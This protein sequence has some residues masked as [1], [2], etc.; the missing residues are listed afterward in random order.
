M[1]DLLYSIDSLTGKAV[2]YS[3]DACVSG[4]PGVVYAVL[5]ESISLLTCATGTIR[6]VVFN[7]DSSL[8]EEC[9]RLVVNGES[10]RISGSDE[11][12][13]FFGAQALRRLNE[14]SLLKEGVLEDSPILGFRGFKC[15][16]PAPN[17]QSMAEFR[18][19]VDILARY[20]YN[21]IILEIGGAMEFT[22]H[23]E[24]NEGWL[25][26]CRFMNAYSGKPRKIQNGM[27]WEKDSI[28]TTN[29]GGQVV[30]QRMLR[31]L[32]AYC[33]E[34]H[35][36][37]IPEMPS[38]SHCDYLLV[39]HPELAERQ[40]DPFP[41]TACPNHPGYY[42]LL[43]DLFDEII[44]VFHPKRMHI[45]H[46]EWYSIALCPRCKGKN[47]ADLFAEDICRC[48]EYLAGRGI[49][50]MVWSDKLCASTW[51]NGKGCGGSEV[52]AADSV[53]SQRPAT[54]QAIDKLPNDISIMH[55]FYVNRSLVDA[56]DKRGFPVVLGNMY[57]IN[58][59]DWK[60]TIAKNCV[61]GA[62]CSNWGTTDI[63]TLQRNGMLFNIVS[64]AAA[65]WNPNIGSDNAREVALWAIRELYRLSNTLK[66]CTMSFLE[67][68]HTCD[69]KRNATGYCDGIFVDEPKDTLGYHRFISSTGKLYRFPVI[70]GS[71]I[72]A[73]DVRYERKPHFDENGYYFDLCLGDSRLW[74]ITFSTLPELKD[75]EPTLFR[76]RYPNPEPGAELSYDGFETMPGY[77]D[78][79][80]SL[81]EFSLK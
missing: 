73:D 40:E 67:V 38:L 37:V 66:N 34:R 42:P 69:L 62:S 7:R 63:V 49:A 76:T 17:D 43:F 14:A 35:L 56:F 19:L 68:V 2:F 12:A 52:L 11:R 36:E 50:T 18:T 55:W 51:P 15:F 8:K 70:Y 71:N 6:D 4:C 74:G 64:L 77:E 41:D 53:I 1:N 78:I 27:R 72:S 25:E 9:Y 75:G 81:K 59:P 3:P 24:I 29:G 23:P 22:R 20:K 33:R 30:P 44:D 60:N 28:H 45:G 10:V 13:L 80:V 16:L 5:A 48:R 47:A 31:E 65:S 54:W 26:Y 61:T 39:R 46:D 58:Q 21:T 79:C 32:I 57:W